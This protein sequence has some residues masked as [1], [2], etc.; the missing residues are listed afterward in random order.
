MSTQTQAEGGA[1]LTADAFGD[2]MSKAVR[3]A[4]P[5]K[6][7]AVSRSVSTLCEFALRDAK[8]IS[9][10]A[11]KSINA[12]IAEIDKKLSEQINQILHHPDFQ[13]LEGTWRGLSY[14]VNNTETDETLK[15]K[16]FNISKTD[17]RKTLSKYEGTA[18]D[19]SPV[20]KKIYEDQYGVAG[21]QPYG[22]LIGGYEFDHSA[23]DVKLLTGLSQI[24]AAAHAP[25]ITSP[26]PSLLQMES[27]RE[28]GNPRDLT[29]IFQSPEYAAWRSLRKSDDAKYLALAMP[30]FLSRIPYGAKTAP[31]DE[32][33]FEEDT[34]GGDHQKYT[35]S[36]AAF[37]MGANMTRAFKLYGWCA[38][39]RGTE[40][41]GIV[42][43]LP[44]HTFPSDEGGVD[45]KCPTEIAITDRREAEL[46]KNGMMPLCHYKNTD[47]AVF[48]GAQSLQE[49]AIYEDPDATSN[50]RLAARL[51][52]LMA[53]CRF[54]HYLKAMVRDKIG[55][56]KER[57]DMEQWLN[58]WIS[59][60]TCDSKAS[61][62]MK[63]R[64]PLAS[65]EVKVEEVPG[66]PGY[67]TS[68]FFL[69]PHFQLEG[70]T[71][72]LRLVSKLPSAKG[73]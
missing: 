49:P 29:K 58:K 8:L 44:V 2:L 14:L 50:A 1:A 60:F 7:T 36:N 27:W 4:T 23:S 54:A 33:A 39:I 73:G 64:Y 67:Y 69:R 61:E 25:F 17:L 42:E 3:A 10:D 5:E 41:G 24:A 51:P 37:A 21:G 31:V 22:A 26:S 57:E 38:R 18:W 46:A 52:Y 65:A 63:A 20:F 55:S 53:T 16:V 15:I 59:Q 66:N 40:S 28:L 19:Q 30:R 43:K 6:R 70:L 62:E 35:W 68:K 11:L 71:V 13:S 34:S 12:L 72:S 47:Y 56:F 45:A 32:F 48:M 9:G